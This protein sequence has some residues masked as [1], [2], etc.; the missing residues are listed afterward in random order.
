MPLIPM[1]DLTEDGFIEFNATINQQNYRVVVRW[2]EYNECA[3]VQI[4]SNDEPLLDGDFPLVCNGV[5]DVDHR[6]LPLLL[7]VHQNGADLPPMRE[8]FN[9]YGFYYET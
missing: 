9:N 1:P 6:K 2:S 3:F 8:T 5:I 7:F 4:Y